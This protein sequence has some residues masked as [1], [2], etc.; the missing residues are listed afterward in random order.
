MLPRVTPLSVGA[1]LLLSAAPSGAAGLS[2]A[3]A[4]VQ[5]RGPASAQQIIASSALSGSE[6]TVD[7]T[8][9]ARF[10]SL[11]PKVARVS[12]SGLVTPLRDGVTRICVTAG[13]LSCEVPVT[14]R[15]S[16]H[17]T[18]PTFSNDIL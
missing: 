14:V 16:A 11:N 10:V 18:P 4:S 13:R 8:A 15:D 6:T 17:E 5:L 12:A 3:P 2:A 7:W 9:G 1:L